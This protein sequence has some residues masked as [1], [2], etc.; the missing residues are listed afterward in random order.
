MPSFF[1]KIIGQLFPKEQAN[2]HLPI[3]EEPLKRSENF[4]QA[5]FRWLNE[6]QF[7]WLTAKTLDAYQA[8]KNKQT[9][10]LEVHI[11]KLSGANGIAL[12]YSPLM[13]PQDLQ[14]LADLLKERTTNMGYKHYTSDRKVFERKDYLET[15]E[16]HYL[17]PNT[18]NIQI[19][20]NEYFKNKGSCNQ[21]FGNIL[22]ENILID[23]KPSFLRFQAFYYSDYLYTE[24]LPFELL[25]E[26]VLD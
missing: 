17:K 22:I 1:D 11:L 4:Q 18:T 7:R 8:K 5:Y 25:L 24:V 20:E 9:T 26:T 21:L 14:F 15:I 12:T 10:D 16:K 19:D 23:E 6:G 13:Q 3:L 2:P